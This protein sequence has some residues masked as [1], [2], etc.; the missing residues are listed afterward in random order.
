MK[1]FALSQPFYVGLLT[2]WEMEATLEYNY[3]LPL[4]KNSNRF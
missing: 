3:V 2:L 4:F 1:F